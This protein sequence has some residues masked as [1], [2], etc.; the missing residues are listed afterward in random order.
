MTLRLPQG[1]TWRLLPVSDDSK[2][3]GE[4]R[5][6]GG[7]DVGGEKQRK[8]RRES[9]EMQDWDWKDGGM[10]CALSFTGLCGR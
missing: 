1:K 7:E 6:G 3:N 9:A 10:S 4:E 5:R 8:K 2:L